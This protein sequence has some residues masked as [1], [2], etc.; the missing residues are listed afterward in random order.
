LTTA[1][2]SGTDENFCRRSGGMSIGNEFFWQK[3]LCKVNFFPP[4]FPFR[5][6]KRKIWREKNTMQKSEFYFA[7]E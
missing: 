4:N 2:L 1:T 5:K 3:L 7:K 6:Y